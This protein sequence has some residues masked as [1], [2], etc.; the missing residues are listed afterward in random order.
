MTGPQGAARIEI[1]TS[2]TGGFYSF[3]NFRNTSGLTMSPNYYDGWISFSG[4]GLPG[5][6][7][8]STPPNWPTFP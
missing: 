6:Q 5:S 3:S 1:Y 2:S 4:F 8:N 7:K